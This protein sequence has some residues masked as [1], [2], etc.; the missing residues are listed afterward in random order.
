MYFEPIAS[1]FGRSKQLRQQPL[2]AKEIVLGSFDQAD[3][4]TAEKA[5]IVEND[6]EMRHAL[7]DVIASSGI[8]VDWA[9]DGETAIGYLSRQT[10]DVVILDVVLPKISGMDIMEHLAC[11][12]PRT[13]VNTIVLT[14]IDSPSEIRRLFPDV[15]NVFAKPIPIS[16]LVIEV[17]RFI[18]TGDERN[19]ASARKQTA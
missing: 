19:R 8:V 6:A 5:L 18:A 17:Q 13:L 3:R 10:Y 4:Y 14:D 15:R 11:T 16:R 1:L 2:L 7:V 12:Q 9:A